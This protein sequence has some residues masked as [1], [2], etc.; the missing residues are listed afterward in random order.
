MSDAYDA[1]LKQIQER[2]DLILGHFVHTWRRRLAD[3]TLCQHVRNIQHLTGGHLNYGREADQL[4]SV[5]QITA[6]DVYDFI[7]DWLPRK[8]WVDSERRVKR[9]LASIK[10]YVQFMAEQGY[11]PTGVAADIVRT[12]KEERVDMIH[13]A[14]AYFDE[15]IEDE[16]LE[17]FRAQLKDLEERWAALFPRKGSEKGTSSS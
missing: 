15:P 1:R 17:D 3:D 7:T 8:S 9:Y 10:K 14:V 12:L 6:G 2:N 11:M 4:R 16:S 5:D 13:A